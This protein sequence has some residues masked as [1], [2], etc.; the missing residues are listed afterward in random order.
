MY[1]KQIKYK[2]WSGTVGQGQRFSYLVGR[3]GGDERSFCYWGWGLQYPILPH[4]IVIPNSLVVK[5]QF[6]QA[7]LTFITFKCSQ[8]TLN[9][10]W[11]QKIDTLKCS[12]LLLSLHNWVNSNLLIQ[13]TI[14][15]LYSA[16]AH[17]PL[18]CL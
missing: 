16:Y 8:L 14:D 7:L 17:D 12:M 6:P 9:S 18:N 11:S 2:F 15:N 13:L 3:W 4:P 5:S 1:E 10:T